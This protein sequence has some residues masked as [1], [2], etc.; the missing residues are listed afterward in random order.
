IDADAVHFSKTLRPVH[1]DARGRFKAREIAEQSV[2][3]EKRGVVSDEK[4][5][6]EAEAR[7][8]LVI[9]G[10]LGDEIDLIQ[11]VT[12][13]APVEVRAEVDVVAWRVRVRG[14][15]LLDPPVEMNRGGRRQRRDGLLAKAGAAEEQRTRSPEDSKPGHAESL[16]ADIGGKAE[17]ITR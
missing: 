14:E 6:S 9:Q 4:V 7:L 13:G 10:F 11:P 5:P 17:E 8:V 16:D 3:D 15:S 12:I 1:S 2:G